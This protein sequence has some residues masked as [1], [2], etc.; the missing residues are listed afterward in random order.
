MSTKEKY[1]RRLMRNVE[2][3]ILDEYRSSDLWLVDQSE[4]R[5]NIFTNITEMDCEMKYGNRT[6]VG[7]AVNVDALGGRRMDLCGYPMGW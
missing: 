5:C 4:Q 7:K 2:Y 1:L 6:M 3:N